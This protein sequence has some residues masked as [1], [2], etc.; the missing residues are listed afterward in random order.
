MDYLL[1]LMAVLL[2]LILA[3]FNRFVCALQAVLS[4]AYFSQI[5][6]LA[7]IADFPGLFLTVLGVTVLL[8]LLWSSLHFK[9]TN[10]LWLEMTV[11]L[12]HGKGEDVW[13]FLAVPMDISF[14]NFDLDLAGNVVAILSWL[15]VTDHSLWTI[16]IVFGCLIPLAVEFYVVCA[17]NIVDDFLLHIAIG[18][19]NIG[20]L[21]IILRRHID[22]ISGI[23]DPVLASE[24]SLDLI[25]FLQCL[26]MNGFD[27]VTHQFIYIKANTF[28]V[29]LND[30]GTIIVRLRFAFLAILGPTSS[31]SVVF[32]LIL[33]HDLLD[34]VTI[35]ILVN[36]IPTNICLAYIRVVLLGRS[37]SRIFRWRRYRK[38]KGNKNSEARELKHVDC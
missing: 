1:N 14:A 21:V 9:L 23:A 25:R 6:L 4:L 36:A 31:F 28:N 7:L 3:L 27:Q 37:G 5:L 20:A 17:R 33:E 12:F 35:G 29:C 11:L 38:R 2:L 13:E 10:F 16:P 32:A 22:F 8:C 19:L 30:T 24:A 18:C 26:V 15:P 34:H